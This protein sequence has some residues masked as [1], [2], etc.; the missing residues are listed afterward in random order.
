MGD[1]IFQNG[2]AYGKGSGARILDMQYINM[3]AAKNSEP[4]RPIQQVKPFDWGVLPWS[5]WGTNNLLAKEMVYRYQNLRRLNS[6]IEGKTRF[7]VCQGML[8]AIIK[9]DNTG[10]G[11]STKYL[12]GTEV[13]DFLEANN[14]FLN[15]LVG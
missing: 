5:P 12:D 4:A 9:T 11:I 1:V 14:S 10:A 15:T 3:A 8:P 7:A 6:V 13:N 2:I